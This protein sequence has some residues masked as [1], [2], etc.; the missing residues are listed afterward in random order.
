MENKDLNDLK[1]YV[2]VEE[3]L[4]RVRGN[5]TIYKS[6]LQSFT[7]NNYMDGL[8]RDFQ[9]EN[10]ADAAQTLHTLKGVSANLSLKELNMSIVILESQ[11]KNGIHKRES[12]S[13]LEIVMAETM[14]NIATI[15]ENL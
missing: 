1:Q 3:A 8:R 6:L 10:W 13:D 4:T 2:D 14:T 5:K 9:K 7:K 12:F 11:L 15:S